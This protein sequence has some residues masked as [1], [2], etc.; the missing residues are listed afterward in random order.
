MNI[1]QLRNLIVNKISIIQFIQFCSIEPAERIYCTHGT[2]HDV[3][4]EENRVLYIEHDLSVSFA[5]AASSV[6]YPHNDTA[7]V[8]YCSLCQHI[9]P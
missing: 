5:P 2:Y 8:D 6:N 4:L 7:H 9:F 1:Q 3:P